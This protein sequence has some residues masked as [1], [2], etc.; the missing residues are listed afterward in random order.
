MTSKA[1]S[2]RGCAGSRGAKDLP[3][4]GVFDLH[5]SFTARMAEKANGLVAYRRIRA[6]TRRR[7]PGARRI[8]WIAVCAPGSGPGWWWNRRA[9]S[10]RLR[11]RAR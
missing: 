4:F 3:T 5:T 7:A 11:A 9:S 2:S 6:P 10:G 8:F 1:R